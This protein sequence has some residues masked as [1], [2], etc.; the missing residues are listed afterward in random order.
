MRTVAARILNPLLQLLDER[1]VDSHA[2]LQQVGI[3]D[4]LAQGTGEARV[5]ESQ[6]AGLCALANDRTKDDTL[7]LT[8]GLCSSPAHLGVLGHVLLNCDTVGQ[9][10]AQ[11]QRYWLLVHDQALLRI[12]SR[13]GCATVALRRDPAAD[14]VAARALVDYLFGLLLRLSGS[15]TGGEQRGRQ[16]LQG[17]DCRH[18]EPP[19]ASLRAYQQHFSGAVLRFGQARNALHFDAALLEH[20]VPTA[21]AEL[22][23]VLAAQAER[24]L[25]QISPNADV[26][27]RVETFIGNALPG[28]PPTLTD[29]AAHCAMSRATLQRKLAAAGTGYQA[30]VDSVR[31]ALADQLLTNPNLSIGEVAFSLGYGDTAAFHHAYK[32]WT[33]LTPA[34]ARA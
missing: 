14:P 34:Q 22:R 30:L 17:V 15:L 24:Q 8:A 10:W 3:T 26:V 11:L 1:G 13:A 6:L 31:H 28:E 27:A 32:R 19:V 4:R 33:G 12:A 7:C 25:Q 18:P 9:A 2:L 23:H 5:E 21:D 29:A 20:P 16:Y